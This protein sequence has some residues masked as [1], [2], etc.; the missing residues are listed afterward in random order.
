MNF[1]IKMKYN[2][3]SLAFIVDSVSCETIDYRTES[4]TT[5]HFPVEIIF[6]FL[7]SHIWDIK[8]MFQSFLPKVG[9]YFTK[10]GLEQCY[11][12]LVCPSLV[13]NISIL[14][15]FTSFIVFVHTV[16]TFSPS[17][18]ALIHSV[19]FIAVGPKLI[20]KF[21]KNICS[22]KQNFF[23]FVSCTA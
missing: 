18:N 19:S 14:Y 3:L 10:S 6:C 9:V 13:N 15:Y 7:F 1:M 17:L 12:I 8:F 21:R 2:L 16:V 23:Y 4:P 20:N 22:Y 5:C 11:I